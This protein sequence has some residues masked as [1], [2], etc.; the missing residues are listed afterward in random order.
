MKHGTVKSLLVIGVMASVLM[1]GGKTDAGWNHLRGYGAYGYGGYGYSPY[2]GYTG[3]SYSYYGGWGHAGY[4]VGYGGGYGCGYGACATPS[5]GCYDPCG[6]QGCGHTGCG[7]LSRWKYRCRSHHYGYLARSCYQP[8]CVTTC[9]ST[10]GSY[11]CGCGSSGMIYDNAIEYGVPS[12]VEEQGPTPAPAE[13]QDM[14]LP[15]TTTSLDRNSA[16]LTV[17][18]P[19]QARVYVN[20][21]ATRSTG[22][23]RRYVSRNLTPGFDYTYEVKAEMVVDGKPVTQVKMVKLQAGQGSQLA[24]DIRAPQSLETSL[25]LH[26]PE[27][28]EVYLAGNQTK[29]EGVV[30]TFKTTRLSEGQAWSDYSIRVVVNEDGIDRTEEKKLTLRA[31]ESRELTFDF[32]VDKLAAR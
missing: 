32:D 24:F 18:V 28:A 30:R 3:Y 16:F 11:D 23:H 17:S 6:Y 10:C 26:V 22:S 20:G 13:G 8:C 25:T 14:D 19:S 27:N 7:L 5:Y 29:G 12:G 2:I 9:C 31:G 4:G 21:I 15:A 1:I